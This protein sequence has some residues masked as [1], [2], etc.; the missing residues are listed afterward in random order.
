[1]LDQ[2]PAAV[3]STRRAQADIVRLGYS[4]LPAGLAATL[5]VTVGLA[6]IVSRHPGAE[7]VWL[8]LTAMLLISAW[9]FGAVL[10]FRRIKRD[11]EQAIAGG[12]PETVV[13]DL[14]VVDVEEQHSGPRPGPAGPREREREPVAEEA[15][16][17]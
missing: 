15:P 5:I 14:E 10:W 7:H 16:V 6:W 12:V 2:P 3:D 9:R 17:G 8:W 1:M 4:D 13:D 11:H